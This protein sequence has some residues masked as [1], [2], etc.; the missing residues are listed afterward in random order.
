MTSERFTRRPPDL[1]EVF[2]RAEKD[3]I[4]SFDKAA[5]DFIKKGGDLEKTKVTVSI[6][7]AVD[8]TAHV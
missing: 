8:D 2:D 4:K 1:E 7:F 6:S 5:V 3:F